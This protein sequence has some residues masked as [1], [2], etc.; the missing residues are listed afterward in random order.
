MTAD[1][2]A[3]DGRPELGGIRTGNVFLPASEKVMWGSCE[4]K[5]IK[6]VL[7]FNGY[8]KKTSYG[9]RDGVSTVDWP[10]LA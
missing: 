8:A 6:N 1:P 10:G 7:V 5:H 2:K 3:E 9:F 4:C